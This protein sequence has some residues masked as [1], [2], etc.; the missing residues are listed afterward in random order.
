[1]AELSFSLVFGPAGGV[2]AARC[3]RVAIA[4]A[5]ELERQLDRLDALGREGEPLVAELVE[6]D[7][8]TR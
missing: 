7:R 8:G 5:G 2:D 6:P 4:S 3:E 1:M